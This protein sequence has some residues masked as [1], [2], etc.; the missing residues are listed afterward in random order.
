MVLLAVA[1]LPNSLSFWCSKD[2]ATSSTCRDFAWNTHQKGTIP[3]WDGLHLPCSFG[4]G[5]TLHC[6]ALAALAEEMEHLKTLNYTSTTPG[7]LPVSQPACKALPRNAGHHH[8]CQ[9]S[10]LFLHS[11]LRGLPPLTV[12]E[13]EMLISQRHM[14]RGLGLPQKQ[15]PVKKWKSRSLFGI[16]SCESGVTHEKKDK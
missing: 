11:C 5:H 10:I 1:C 14:N 13:R 15:Y 2:K 9:S 6:P 7:L 3:T 12:L 16:D 8:H 4:A